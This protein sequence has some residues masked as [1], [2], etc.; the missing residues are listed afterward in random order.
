MNYAAFAGGGGG[1][2]GSAAHRLGSVWCSVLGAGWAS[3]RATTNRFFSAT[4]SALSVATSGA[5]D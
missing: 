3:E 2:Q 1:G 5:I 4:R